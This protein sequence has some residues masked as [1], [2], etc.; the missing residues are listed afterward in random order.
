MQ[1][2]GL[3]AGLGLGRG[4]AGREEAEGQMGALGTGTL[5]LG[6]WFSEAGLGLSEQTME[7]PVKG[8][9]AEPGAPHSAMSLYI[10]GNGGPEEAGPPSLAIM[11]AAALPWCE[12]KAPP[13]HTASRVGR[14]ECWGPQIGVERVEAG[15][16]KGSRH[17]RA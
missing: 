1:G 10:Q 13:I 5:E 8:L 7:S 14:V 4:G 3:W 16:R 9:Q 11:W 6:T 12:D 17:P 2:E 15:R